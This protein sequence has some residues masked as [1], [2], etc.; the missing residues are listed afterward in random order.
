MAAT[1]HRL[2][3]AP[4]LAEQ[5]YR[6]LQQAIAQGH[7]HFSRVAALALALHQYNGAQA[8]AAIEAMLTAPEAVCP[9]P[10]A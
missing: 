5:A 2:D 7:A 6:A 3:T 4:D 1:L 9:G 8:G 10:P